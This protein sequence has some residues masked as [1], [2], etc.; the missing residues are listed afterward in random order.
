MTEEIR[1]MQ[2][3]T[4]L[5]TAMP[6]LPAAFYVYRL[7]VQEVSGSGTAVYDRRLQL[8]GDARSV[9]DRFSSEAALSFQGFDCKVTP[10]LTYNREN[11]HMDLR[12]DY[13]Q[14]TAEST[15]TGI[16]SPENMGCVCMESNSK[17]F[18]IHSRK[19]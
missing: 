10:T 3:S 8:T 18:M 6:R 14:F 15:C 2:L 13:N 5:V 7:P 17:L 16:S 12:Y 4:W 9:F 19:W 11:G 1:Y